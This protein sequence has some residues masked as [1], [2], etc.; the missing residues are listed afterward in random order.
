[1]KMNIY[2]VNTK[3]KNIIKIYSFESNSINKYVWNI[4]NNIR[5]VFFFMLKKTI[6]LKIL[7]LFK[8]IINLWKNRFLNWK[9]TLK[10]YVKKCKIIYFLNIKNYYIKQLLCFNVSNFLIT[11]YNSKYLE[12]KFYLNNL[13]F[14]D[15]YYLID[16]KKIYNLYIKYIFIIYIWLYSIKLLNFYLI[17]I[18]SIP[19]KKSLYTVLRSP[20][21]DKKSREQFKIRKLK[22]NFYY[23]S[24]LSNNILFSNY[25]NET[26]LIK[27]I[28]TIKKH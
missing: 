6:I 15:Y 8:L 17:N 9:N 5:Y 20:H 4:R 1:M 16:I 7:F 3:Y 11:K 22:K 14:I 28:E 13:L 18:S 12:F 25:V 19:S 2:K 26:I 24:F 23:P 10:Y 21:K 27:N